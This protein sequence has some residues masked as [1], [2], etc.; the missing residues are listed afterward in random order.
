MTIAKARAE[1]RAGRT[2]SVELTRRCLEVIAQRNP[3]LNAFITVTE[4]IARARA[5]ELDAELARGVDR[6]PL[7]GIPIAHK[8]IICTKGI[9][10]TSGSKLYADSV[11]GEDAALVTQLHAS[12]AVL[13]GKTGLH[14]LAYGITSNNPHYGAIRNPHDPARI[15]GGSSGGAAV[16]VATGMALMATGTDTGGSVR[17]PAS[18]CGVAGLKPTYGLL[19]RSGIRPLG[20]TLDH[21][22]PLAP[23]VE[24]VALTMAALSALQPVDGRGLHGLKLGLPENYFFE[25]SQPAVSESVRRAAQLAEELGAHIVPVRVPDIDGLNTVSRVILLAEATAVYQKHL[26]SGR[27]RIGPDVLALLD[28]GRLLPAVDYV[29]AQRLRTVFRREFRRLFQSVDVL[30]T[31]TTPATAPLIGQNEVEIGSKPQDVRLAATSFV[32]GFNLLGLP[33]LS[34]PCGRDAAGLPI[35][36]QIIGRAGEDNVV[37]QIGA[38]IEK[39]YK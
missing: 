3:E 24:D 34:L 16:A 36:L 5:A 17:I 27:D 20:L 30:F 8:D 37:L 19:N 2:T 1:L 10:T 26:D 13:V 25:R 33:A 23:T 4:E 9:L 39:E 15:P 29:N 12:G 31:P 14:E 32:R 6:G 22:G 11:P 21:P 18:F 38:A 35:G 28:Q 7:H